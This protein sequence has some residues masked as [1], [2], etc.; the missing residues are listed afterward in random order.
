MTV[1]GVLKDNEFQYAMM[2]RG[3]IATHDKLADAINYLKIAN[4]TVSEVMQGRTLL[5]RW[6]ADVNQRMHTPDIDIA[7]QAV[8][9]DPNFDVT[10]EYTELKNRAQSIIAWMDI[11]QP[12]EVK[13]TPAQTKAIRDQWQLFVDFVNTSG[14]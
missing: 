5:E 4:V 6:L 13:Y 10:A 11:N 7:G 8:E 3:T 9:E 2:K 1:P 12:A 14:A